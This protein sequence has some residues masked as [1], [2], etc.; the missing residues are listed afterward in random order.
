L[1]SLCALLPQTASATKRI[2]KGLILK[3]LGERQVHDNIQG[4][5]VCDNDSRICDLRLALRIQDEHAGDVGT[6]ER[7]NE[8]RMV[9]VFKHSHEASVPHI[10][11]LRRNIPLALGNRHHLRNGFSS[12]PLACGNQTDPLP[13]FRY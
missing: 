12:F 1:V 6:E 9:P 3:T 4:H 11:S 7:E 2:D 5:L 8:I 13:K 10:H